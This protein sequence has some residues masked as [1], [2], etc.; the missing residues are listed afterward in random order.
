MESS[1]KSDREKYMR[2]VVLINETVWALET[3][4]HPYRNPSGFV[5]AFKKPIRIG[6]LL[7]AAVGKCVC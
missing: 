7:C 2:S 3:S 1:G 4:A 6:V 5:T